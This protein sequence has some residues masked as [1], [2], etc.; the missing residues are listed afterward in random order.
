VNENAENQ[1]PIALHLHDNNPF[2]FPIALANY[3]LA[4]LDFVWFLA[5]AQIIYRNEIQQKSCI[6]FTPG[7]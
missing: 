2:H 3:N 5:S 4:R 7:V 1:Q 6:V